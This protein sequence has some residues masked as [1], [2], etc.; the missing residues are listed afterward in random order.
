MKDARL[1]K[2]AV[3]I[4]Q[5]CAEHPDKLLSE[6]F[7]D[8]VETITQIEP[9]GDHRDRATLAITQIESFGDLV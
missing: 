7:D 9:F 3:Q 8:W 1:Q 6:R 4:A 2:R 5:G